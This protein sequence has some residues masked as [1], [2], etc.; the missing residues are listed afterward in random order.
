MRALAQYLEGPPGLQ[1]FV[2]TA[3]EAAISCARSIGLDAHDATVLHVS[4]RVTVRLLPCD[5]VARVAPLT[6]RPSAEF[7]VE[8]AQRLADTGSPV[9]ALEPRVEPRVHLLGDFVINFWTY[10]EHSGT[11]TPG[12]YADALSQLHA[13][14]RQVE[15]GT[16]HFTDRVAHAQRLIDTPADTPELASAD[17]EFLSK[18]LRD[19]KHAIQAFGAPEQLLH[20]EPHPGNL[21]NT[22][23]GPVFIDFETCCRG[24]IEFDIA[25]ASAEVGDHYPGLDP[26]LLHQ[27]RALMLAMVAAW[28]WDR[29]D[30]FAG[31]R[32]MGIDFIAAL[33]SALG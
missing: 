33:R 32:Q 12:A 16:P 2:P 3:L 28:R 1:P 7:E 27:C 21:L 17:R 10:Y 8:V 5:T 11:V 23:A 4:N 24:P 25:H 26:I 29:G 30:Q 22:P 20:G 13:G 9:A 14:L 19:L 31:G 18:A 6:H 15:L